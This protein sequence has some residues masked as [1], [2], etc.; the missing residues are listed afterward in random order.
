MR[1]QIGALGLVLPLLAP[2][3]PAQADPGPSAPA[4]DALKAADAAASC[5]GQ[6]LRFQLA[7]VRGRI[8]SGVESVSQRPIV[9][10]YYSGY[11][12]A[13]VHEGL[14]EQLLRDPVLGNGGKLRDTWTGFA[15]VDYKEGWFVP[16]WA[17]D[18]ALRE[19]MAKYPNAIFLADR[20]ECLTKSGTSDKC[21]GRERRP[22]FRSNRGSVVVLYRGAILHQFEGPTNAA[23]FL[24]KLRRLAEQAQAGASFCQARQAVAW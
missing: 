16:A 11:K 5:G 3:S 21:P 15:I 23:L 24:H 1:H 12:S 17:V 2:P 18:K 13:P 7:D 10:A 22:Y 20:G 8:Y 14:R 6:P 4:R 9:L 19:K